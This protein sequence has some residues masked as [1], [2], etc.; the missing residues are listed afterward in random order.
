MRSKLL[1]TAMTSCG[2][3]L[4]ALATTSDVIQSALKTIDAEIKPEHYEV[5]QADLDADG[6]DDVFVLMNDQSGYRGSGGTT[7]FVFLSKKDKLSSVGRI[8]VV[9]DP[10]YLRKTASHG[11]RH[12]LV[13]VS[14]GGAKPGLAELAF[15]GKTYPA[16]PGEASAKLQ[17][18]DQVIFAEP[19]PPLS[20]T[21]T[22]QGISFQVFSPNTRTGNT[23]TLTP[24]GL[25][26]DNTLITSPVTGLI[27]RI[28]TADINSD[29]SP[30]VYIYGFD[31]K[32][33][34]VLAFS[35]NKKKSLSSI[36]IPPLTPEQ[37]KGHRGQDE[38]AVV[39]GILARRF[40]IYPD[41]NSATK[42]TDKTRQ[43]QYRLV[44]GEATWKLKVDKVIEF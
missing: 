8:G 23:V 39:E 4:A 25:E 43:L 14:G 18:D 12:L 17:P 42:P 10:I 30:E 28:E 13:T 44:P 7:L 1:L 22:L 41:D 9:N 29:G 21:Q 3:N 26:Q 31:G 32:S 37:L 5:A 38:F 35:T 16:S 34:T 11:L 40:P 27:T 6:T 20:E 19:T 2:L 33:Q 24:T 36:T 15:D